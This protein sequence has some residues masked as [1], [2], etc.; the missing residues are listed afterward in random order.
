MS[1][2]TRGIGVDQAR[3]LGVS[4]ALSVGSAALRQRLRLVVAG[5]AGAAIE[6]PGVALG[7]GAVKCHEFLVE[8]AARLRLQHEMVMTIRAPARGWHCPRWRAPPR[9][10]GYSGW[11]SRCAGRSTG[12]AGSRERGA[13]GAATSRRDLKTAQLLGLTVPQTILGRADEVIE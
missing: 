12:S 8:I 5:D 3:R 4:P 11:R 13:R 6:D 10:S 2:R 9:Q 7:D 1:S